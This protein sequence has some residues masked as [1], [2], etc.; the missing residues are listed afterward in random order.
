M[1]AE[2]KP[3]PESTSEPETDYVESDCV[4]GF[5]VMSAG[6]SRDMALRAWCVEQLKDDNGM[7]YVDL[8]PVAAQLEAY[9]K[10]GVVPSGASKLRAAK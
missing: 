8:W 4:P 3:E 1:S 2:N 7:L 5:A 10:T 6:E 9:I